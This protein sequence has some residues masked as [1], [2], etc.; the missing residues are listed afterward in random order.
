[1][2]LQQ[3]RQQVFARDGY[4]CVALK[5][6]PEHRCGGPFGPIQPGESGYLQALTLEHVTK[7]SALGK[8]A[9][10]RLEEC[11]TL[12]AA[13]NV[14]GWA[15]SHRHEERVYLAELYPEHWADVPEVQP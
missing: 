14:H 3:F 2:E 5:L 4:R 15:S 7:R 9:D 11:L 13:A 10:D 12:C 1:L 8:R 6:D